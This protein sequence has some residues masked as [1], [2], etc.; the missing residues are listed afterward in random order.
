MCIRDSFYIRKLK[1]FLSLSKKNKVYA[2]QW[3]R[4]H[5]GR[6]HKGRDRIVSTRLNLWCENHKC[7]KL[8]SKRLNKAL[9]GMCLEDLGLFNNICSEKDD[10]YGL[11]SLPMMAKLLGDSH[12]SSVLGKT[13]NSRAC[14]FKFSSYMKNRENIPSY[15]YPLFTEINNQLLAQTDSR[16]RQG[17][18][19]LPGSLQEFDKKG[20]DNFLYTPEIKVK[21]T[22]T[23]LPLITA[24]PFPTA[25]PL[26]TIAP[27]PTP[28][29]TVAPTA[30]PVKLS[31]FGRQVERFETKKL[32]RLRI[33]LNIFNKD[34]TFSKRAK[35]RL[36]NCLLYTSP[37]PRD[38]TR[39]R[40]PSSA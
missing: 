24:T 25:A 21:P 12:I 11:Y 34:Y 1:D 40:M 13:V 38:R 4:D 7:G 18:L 19:F 35:A 8:S 22:P 30:V 10:F 29:P 15:I 23:P 39:S 37:S 2:S 31:Y 28:V 6:K 14:L 3:V 32:K 20:L 33:R 27:T 9:Y 26:P 16:Y 5:K 17:M 36:G